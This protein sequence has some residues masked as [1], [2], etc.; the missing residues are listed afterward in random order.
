MVDIARAQGIAVRPDARG[1]AFNADIKA[2]ALFLNV[3][4]SIGRVA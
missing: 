1:F 4:T 3:G 2:L